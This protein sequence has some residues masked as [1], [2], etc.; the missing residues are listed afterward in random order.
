V[1]LVGKAF[2]S[3]SLVGLVDTLTL[4]AVASPVRPGAIGQSM[5]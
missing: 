3:C 1:A 2:S 5:F 4:R